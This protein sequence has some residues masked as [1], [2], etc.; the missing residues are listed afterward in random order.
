MSSFSTPYVDA[1]KSF[2]NK[3]GQ[4]YDAQTHHFHGEGAHSLIEAA[5]HSLQ[6]GSWVLDL[7]TGTG[8]V[9]F[10]AAKTVGRT[11]RVLGIDIS[12]E[13][14]GIASRRASQLGVEDYVEFLQQDV[15]QLALPEMYR[16]KR[17]D[18]VTCGS[19]IAMFPDQKTMLRVVAA[20]LLKPGGVLVADTHDPHVAATVFLEVAVPRGFEAPFDP[21]WLYDP[22]NCFRR[23][24]ED[25]AFDLSSLTTKN[26]P[27]GERKVDAGTP[28]AMERLWQNI[29]V[30]SPWVSFGIEKLGP[31]KMAGI[32]QAFVEE[33]SKYKCPDGF[34]VTEMKQYT[35][36]ATLKS[37]CPPTVDEH[38]DFEVKC[39][40][41]R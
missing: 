21:R 3:L 13:F 22:T 26:L 17:F 15:T 18:G 23:M 24:F 10:A 40:R 30:D 35:A 27:S 14:L 2:Y 41:S 1:L 4:Q 34:I 37:G 32:R 5:G 25:S 11:G 8:N 31:L 33:L 38:V 36:V 20:E 19:A 6:E 7:A 12:D 16:G 29:I 9:A 39:T 28:E